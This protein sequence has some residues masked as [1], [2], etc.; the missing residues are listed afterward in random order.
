[1]VSEKELFDFSNISFYV[2]VSNDHN[3]R[4]LL[5]A[6]F[7]DEKNRLAMLFFD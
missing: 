5:E 4:K 6:L 3:N 7:V 2:F 1:M